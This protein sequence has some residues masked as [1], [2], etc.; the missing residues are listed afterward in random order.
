VQRK[1]SLQVL[2]SFAA[3]LNETGA[4]RDKIPGLD[5]YQRQVGRYDVKPSSWMRNYCGQNREGGG[6]VEKKGEDT[7]E[8]ETARI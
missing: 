6:Y 4:I 1:H 3:R 5:K 7:G 2:Y 8:K